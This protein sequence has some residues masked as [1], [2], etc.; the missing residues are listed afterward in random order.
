MEERFDSQE[1]AGYQTRQTDRKKIVDR[2][3]LKKVLAHLS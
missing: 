1:E 2:N 3:E